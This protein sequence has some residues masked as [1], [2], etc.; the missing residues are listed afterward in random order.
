MGTCYAQELA[1]FK[2]HLETFGKRLEFRDFTEKGLSKFI[3]H[4]RKVCKMEEKTKA[5]AMKLI[6]DAWGM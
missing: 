3:M 4:L 5:N 6:D 1:T 2:L